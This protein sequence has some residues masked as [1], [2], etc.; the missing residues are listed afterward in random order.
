MY[1]EIHTSVFADG[2][3]GAFKGHGEAGTTPE[4]SVQTGQW[5]SGLGV[6]RWLWL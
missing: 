2:G 5:W 6:E 4:G 3:G 1:V